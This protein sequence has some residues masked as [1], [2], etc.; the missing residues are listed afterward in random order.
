MRVLVV[1]D[2]STLRALL[3]LHL[4]R[5]AGREAFFVENGREA[6]QW[7]QSNGAPDLMLLDINMPV[8]NGLEFLERRRALSVPESIPV[9]ILSTE[10]READIDR[11]VAAGAAAYVTKPFTAQSLED[12]ISKALGKAG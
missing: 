4:R 10:G 8:M 1:D 11:G 6:V 5:I 7:I 3:R 12:A 2:S 9:V